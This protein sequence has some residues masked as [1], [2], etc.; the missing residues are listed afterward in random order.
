M[1][2]PFYKINAWIS[3]QPYWVDDLVHVALGLVGSIIT[4]IF[5]YYASAMLWPTWWVRT[6]ITPIVAFLLP[7]ILGLLE[8]ATNLHPD[9]KQDVPGYVAGALLGV[10]ICQLVWGF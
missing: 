2:S 6:I 10:I 3:R 8:E 4:Y 7:V 1:K 9:Y 5:L